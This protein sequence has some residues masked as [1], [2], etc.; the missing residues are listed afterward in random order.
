MLTLTKKKIERYCVLICAFNEGQSIGDMVRQAVSFC[1]HVIVVDDGSE[2]DTVS[3]A[4]AAGATVLKMVQNQGKG[5]AMNEGFRY[6]RNQN[7]DAVI[8]MDGDRRH[9]PAEIPK[10][11]DTYARTGF[12]VLTGNRMHS[13]GRLRF[14]RRW[15]NR[16]MAEWLCRISDVYIP[17]PPCGFRFYR[18]D[19][20]PYII[21]QDTR[22]CAEFEMLINMAQRNIRIGSV[23]I[24][25]VRKNKAS[26]WIPYRDILRFIAVVIVHHRRSRAEKETEEKVV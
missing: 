5:R 22:Y 25:H 1:P 15:V 19:V 9:N 18:G 21:A 2:D 17:D 16:A 8:T 6:A 13:P 12:P 26:K 20:L 24:T 7:F 4:E 14:S 23:S 3:Q 10:F 11:L